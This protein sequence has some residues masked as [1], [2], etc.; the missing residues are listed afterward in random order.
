MTIPDGPGKITPRSMIR[1]RPLTTNVATPTIARTTGIARRNVP[2]STLRAH[3]THFVPAYEEHPSDAYDSVDGTYITAD[4]DIQ[5]LTN[6]MHTGELS[7]PPMKL[8]RQAVHTS[9]AVSIRP[10]S[11]VHS[12]RPPTKARPMKNLATS[13]TD[14]QGIAGFRTH[15]LLYLGLGMI[16]ML[17]MW[18]I[19]NACLNWTNNEIN[20]LKYGYPR[21]YQTD[22][23]VGHNESGGIPSHFIALNLHG[24]IEV[25]ELPGGDASHAHIYV[26][27]QLYGVNSDLAPVTL[28]FVDVNGD[29]KPD[30][31]LL[32]QS[33]HVVFLNENNTFR[34]PNSTEQQKIE[35]F[36]QRHNI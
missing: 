6:D 20:T 26:G 15:P 17:L 12:V 21:S 24:H 2:S 23:F 33:N 22:A 10:I 4:V 11:S 28:R 7:V 31:I 36:L 14:R 16:T 29:H 18:L 19:L 5:P 35:Q 13:H 3:R 25:I 27:P 30:M 32:F 8:R 1:Y 9:P 34:P